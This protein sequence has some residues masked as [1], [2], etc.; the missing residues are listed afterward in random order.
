MSQ[1]L[2]CVCLCAEVFKMLGQWDKGVWNLQREKEAPDLHQT[3]SGV[4]SIYKAQELHREGI[5]AEN[6][7]YIVF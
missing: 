1:T 6:S 7:S 5:Y 2:R 3:Q 4:V